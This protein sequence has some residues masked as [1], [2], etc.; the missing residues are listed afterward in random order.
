MSRERAGEKNLHYQ[1]IKKIFFIFFEN[2]SPPHFTIDSTTTRK[3]LPTTIECTCCFH[4]LNTTLHP[5]L[6]PPPVLFH[7]ESYNMTLVDLS[8]TKRNRTP[9]C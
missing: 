6:D 3:S 1:A 5:P 4:L 9:F 7:V 2:K 8:L